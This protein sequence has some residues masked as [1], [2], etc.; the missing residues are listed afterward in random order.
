MVKSVLCVVVSYLSVLKG[1]AVSASCPFI[2]TPSRVVVKYGDP[3]SVNCNA[4]SDNT[5][6]GWESNY[7]G[8]GLIHSNFVQLNIE[9]AD[10]WSIESECFINRKNSDQ[11]SEQVPITVYKMPDHVLIKPPNMDRPLVDGTNYSVQCDVSNV[12]PAK[13]LVV[14]WYTD[15]KPHSV[16]RFNKTNPSPMNLS[17]TIIIR[18][19][20]NDH[21]VKIMCEAKFDFGPTGPFL[22]PIEST[23][24]APQVLYAPVFNEPNVE[25]VEVPADRKILLDCTA[26]GNP[27]PVY[28]W[29]APQPTQQQVVKGPVKGPILHLVGPFPGSY[30]CT[31]SNSQGSR[32]KQF[33]VTDAPRDHTVLASVIGVLAVLGLL[34]LISGVFF[35][36]NN[37]TFSCN[38]GNYMRGQPI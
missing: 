34:L 33:I 37:G 16:E 3:F 18:A 26:K 32:V 25:M 5:G 31:A 12:A 28:N 17:S 8:T 22:P 23:P 24:V 14:T 38:K 11:C 35:V 6:M 4:T 7:K 21:Q 20:K 30:N 2:I 36:T 10:R 27:A 19:H 29:Q 15:D 9:K 1:L 13:D